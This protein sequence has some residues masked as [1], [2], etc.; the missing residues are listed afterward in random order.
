MSHMVKVKLQAK[1]KLKSLGKND[2]L[3]IT[4]AI[5]FWGINPD[6][7][8]LDVKQ[9][10]GSRLWRLRLGGWRVIFNRQDTIKIY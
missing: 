6:N 3:R 1:I 8:T 2:R 4:D 7:I 5:V 9:L 10:K